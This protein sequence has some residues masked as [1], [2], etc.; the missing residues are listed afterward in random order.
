MKKLISIFALLFIFGCAQDE[1]FI[2]ID[3]NQEV[4]NALVID[5][6]VGIKLASSIVSDR[7]AMNVKLPTEGSYRVKIRHSMTNEL[8]SQEKLTG[9]EG[10]NI[11][12][13][14]VNTLENSSYKLELTKLDH[15]VV[16][17]TLFS[18]L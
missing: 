12:K 3:Q 14:Y 13:V 16:G 11:F 8:I 1:D 17:V 15:T 7:V 18:K 6:L 2:V 9:K 10:D 5:D 4:P